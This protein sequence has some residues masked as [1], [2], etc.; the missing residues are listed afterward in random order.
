MPNRRSLALASLFVAVALLA[1]GCGN[2]SSGSSTSASAAPQQG[3]TLKLLG[4]SDVDHLDT[5]SAYYVASYTLERAFARQL[6]SYPAST[7]TR[8]AN[9]PVADVAT[10]VPTT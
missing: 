4:S 7:D 8:T 1:A 10:E 5:A 6:F 9:T 2:A 3:A